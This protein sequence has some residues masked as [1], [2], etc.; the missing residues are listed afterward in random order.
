MLCLS[1]KINTFDDVLEK[2]EKINSDLLKYIVSDEK[3]DKWKYL[4]GN[5]KVERVSKN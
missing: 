2:A 4:K 5:K 3:L 1:V